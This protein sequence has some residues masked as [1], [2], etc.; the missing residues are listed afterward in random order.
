MADN[1]LSDIVSDL[2]KM[3]QF[4]ESKAN[5]I[6]IGIDDDDDLDLDE[7]DIGEEEEE[8]LNIENNDLDQ[9]DIEVEMEEQVEAN[10][11]NVED[12]KIILE[13]EID[14]KP[15]FFQKYEN[16]EESE[17]SQEP[18][19]IQE[20]EVI[21]SLE[22]HEL[23]PD[24]DL[25]DS[26]ALMALQSA[27]QQSNLADADT[28]D[29][30]KEVISDELVIVNTVQTIIPEPEQ[31]FYYSYA[32]PSNR[33]FHYADLDDQDD[34][35]QS[36]IIDST[37]YGTE[38]YKDLYPSQQYDIDASDVEDDLFL[39][40]DYYDDE[41]NYLDNENDIPISY[42]NALILNEQYQEEL[43]NFIET[44]E[45]SL[46]ENELRQVKLS[47]EIEELSLGR[48]INQNHK[49]RHQNNILARNPV[50]VFHA[51]YFKDIN[52]YTHPPNTDTI[53]KQSKGELDLYL[54]NPRELTYTEKKNLVDAVRE[55]AINK[56]L[57]RLVEEE[58]TV[59]N[60]LRKAGNPEIENI[61]LR[62][63][64]RKLVAEETEIKTLPDSNLFENI[65]EEYDWMMI[66]AK[67]F[68][69]SVSPNTI[70]LMWKNNLH[71]KVN[72]DKWTKAEDQMLL[73]LVKGPD[74]DGLCRSHKDWDRIAIRLG[75][76][77]NAFLCFH[78]YQNKHNSVT[79]SGSNWTK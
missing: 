1:E 64:L 65:N 9:D 8:E 26:D 61:A 56:R 68:K 7:I 70:R 52:L 20:S 3:Q 27:Q 55:D 11:E 45:D 57:I 17:D 54:T 47:Q 29:N 40:D 5:E 28:Q 78:R 35:T 49:D 41:D 59:F 6:D 23:Q 39:D 14:R 48:P 67:V 60:L 2:Q 21:E 76:N 24:N 58:K 12:Y 72:N 36:T 31:D 38:D 79:C 33:E 37:S 32:G 75:T 25:S 42:H 19:R 16:V 34:C 46:K 22:N 69:R 77:R 66:A 10:D 73:D 50:T 18:K 43:R 4:S 15:E 30:E 51:P 63:R 62:Q 74:E 44:L 71:P 13:S 53:A